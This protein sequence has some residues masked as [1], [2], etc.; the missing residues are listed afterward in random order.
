MKKQKKKL[1]EILLDHEDWRFLPNTL[2]TIREKA[3]G[4][5]NSNWEPECFE[6]FLGNFYCTGEKYDW[7]MYDSLRKETDLKTFYNVRLFTVPYDGLYLHTNFESTKN[8]L[9]NIHIDFKDVE[10]NLNNI[11][12]NFEEAKFIKNLGSKYGFTTEFFLLREKREKFEYPDV[13]KYGRFTVVLRNAMCFSYHVENMFLFK[14]TYDEI[15]NCKHKELCK[16]CYK[17]E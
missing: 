17:K 14:K 2:K 11:N 4:K 15:E 16:M 9:E 7:N 10:S 1:Y 12:K 6:G 5:T 3:E 13:N 8:G